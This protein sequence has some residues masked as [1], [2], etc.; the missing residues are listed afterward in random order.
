MKASQIY[1]QRLITIALLAILFFV[2]IAS[3]GKNLSM[4][5]L[6][7]LILAMGAFP[8][9]FGAMVYFTPTLTR[10]APPSGWICW[11]PFLAMATGFIVLIAISWEPMFVVVAAPL[12]I[13]LSSVLLY[14]MGRQSRKSLGGPHPGLSWY[15]A[16]II[17]LIFGLTTIFVAYLNP[18]WWQALRSVHQQL[19]LVGFLGL[20]AI[21]TLQVFLPTVARY[22][23]PESGKRL[24]Q[25]LKFV[26]IGSVFLAA[27]AADIAFCNEIGR[28]VW[29]IPLI[30][31][32]KS[33]WRQRRGIKNPSG[34]AVSLF[35]ALFGFTGLIVLDG[36]T[37][38]H[39]LFCFFLF[40]LVSGA[41]SHLLPLWKW[42]GH[43]I[44]KREAGQYFLARRGALRLLFFYIA[45]VISVWSREWGGGLAG[46]VVLFFA[47]E[48]LW[49]L[50]VIK[51]AD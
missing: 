20:T 21:G 12:G 33:I 4:A 16:A 7:H 39:Y 2:T 50:F 51:D 44:A 26:V 36:I 1:S 38:L 35:G 5:Q 37:N 22:H 9:I 17:F 45:G 41:L 3:Q 28:M 27:G 48:L 15:K 10:T 47:G 34:A 43:S 49:L 24:E 30:A 31:I 23:D 13:L 6:A 18:Q 8:L 32:I 42:P 14:W 19:N 25:H 11:L 29:L 46:L 40:P